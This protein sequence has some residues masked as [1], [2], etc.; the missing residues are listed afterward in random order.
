MPLSKQLK[1]LLFDVTWNEEL[2]SLDAIKAFYVKK[3]TEL[4]A[5]IATLDV[6]LEKLRQ[7][8]DAEEDNKKQKKLA[9]ELGNEWVPRDTAYKEYTDILRIENILYAEEAINECSLIKQADLKKLKKSVADLKELNKVAELKKLSKPGAPPAKIVKISKTKKTEDFAEVEK[10]IKG[11][12]A[13][14]HRDFILNLEKSL[15]AEFGKSMAGDQTEVVLETGEMLLSFMDQCEVYD[16]DSFIDLDEKSVA[17]LSLKQAGC[18]GKQA[19]D[20][21]GL[22]EKADEYKLYVFRYNLVADYLSA[23]DVGSTREYLTSLG[24]AD[25]KEFPAGTGQKLAC[26]FSSEARN[27]PN[28]IKKN[29]SLML[30][31]KDK[32]PRVKK[33]NDSTG[34]EDIQVFLKNRCRR[35]A[36]NF[37]LASEMQ[38]FDPNIG[39]ASCELRPA[40]LFWAYKAA[41]DA[42][43]KYCVS[44]GEADPSEESLDKTIRTMVAEYNKT[45]K[46]VPWEPGSIKSVSELTNCGPESEMYYNFYRHMAKALDK[47]YPCALP[48][49]HSASDHLYLCFI[50]SLNKHPV[51]DGM[52]TTTGG[53]HNAERDMMHR[54]DLALV[55][56][57]LGEHTV[58]FL[59]YAAKSIVETHKTKLVVQATDVLAKCDVVKKHKKDDPI[60]LLPI[61]TS[62][63][64]ATMYAF[65]NDIPLILNVSRIHMTEGKEDAIYKTAEEASGKT[66]KKYFNYTLADGR[67]C[68]YIPN[69][70]TGKYEFVEDKAVLEKLKDKPAY[71]A[72]GYSLHRLG[73]TLP[74]DRPADEKFFYSDDPETFF[75]GFCKMSPLVHV[76]IG[77]AKHPPF[78]GTATTVV[79]EDSNEAGKGGSFDQVTYLAEHCFGVKLLDSDKVEKK[80]SDEGDAYE[81]RNFGDYITPQVV[82]YVK[83]SPVTIFGG[84]EGYDVSLLQEISSFEALAIK[85]DMVNGT[86]GKPVKK[87]REKMAAESGDKKKGPTVSEFTVYLQRRADPMYYYTQHLHATTLG[88]EQARN[89]RFKVGV[90]GPGVYDAHKWVEATIKYEAAYLDKKYSSGS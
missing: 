32:E 38:L 17:R 46:E 60:P 27:I 8:A 48:S 43:R 61:Y 15:C 78:E 44:R 37:L 73:T 13:D 84:T 72:T 64:V 28:A 21:L 56:A 89:A 5:R 42:L 69:A 83:D 87:T 35:L 47:A 90:S 53:N 7:A 39:D 10:I 51:R 79:S 52:G 71:F 49:G 82:P 55:K 6:K 31:N 76:V 24:K 57:R 33:D 68:T 16:L 41:R 88:Y 34:R 40:F 66:I 86:Y 81:G 11:S 63:R 36:I 65:E 9:S 4:K 59:R 29:L 22:F 19:L 45:Y 67:L 23:G 18:C 50:L 77:A 1:Q 3:K 25:C 75:D 2:D 85:L 20:L 54:N 30:P 58:S 74:E 80:K 12:A 26:Y 70:K 62:Q 14:V